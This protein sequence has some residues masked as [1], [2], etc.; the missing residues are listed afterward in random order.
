M[1]IP[2]LLT[3]KEGQQSILTPKVQTRINRRKPNS[4]FNWKVKGGIALIILLVIMGF[5]FWSFM[6][7]NEFFEKN[8][9]Q[10]N[11]ILKVEV[12]PPFEIKERKIE[13]AEAVT[14][15][16][17]LEIPDEA[18]TPI[19]KYICEKWGVYDCKLAIA[20]ARAEGLKYDED[21]E[22]IPDAV[23]VNTNG[24]IDIGIFQINTVHFSKPQ[25]RLRDM[26]DPYKNVD[27]AYSIYEAQSWTP[28]VAFT[29]GSYIKHYDK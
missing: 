26:V 22:L 20:I 17:E 14:I 3:K 5:G 6:K 15:I 23:N 21:G 1:D 24:T 19:E 27:C 11:Q 16:Q 28:W 12:K 10:F 8:Y 13:V 18:K 25:C 2:N 4:R 29:N 9:F 7:V